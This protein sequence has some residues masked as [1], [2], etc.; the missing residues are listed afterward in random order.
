[1]G[2]CVGGDVGSAS[3][4][5]VKARAVSVESTVS[6]S[7]KADIGL[8]KRVI[9]VGRRV[10]TRPP[11]PSGLPPAPPLEPACVGVCV[12]LFPA[13]AEAA[14]E[15]DTASLN[16]FGR[17]AALVPFKYDSASLLL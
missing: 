9:V 16:S 13:D 12:L 8:G 10:G 2:A 11:V 5:K 15:R 3:P 1:M 7:D 4:L 14:A 6:A 17:S